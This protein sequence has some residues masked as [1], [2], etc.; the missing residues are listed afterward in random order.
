MYL[1]LPSATGEPKRLVGFAKVSPKVG[2]GEKVTVTID[3]SA[4]DLPMSYYDTTSHAWTIAPGT[5]TVEVGTSAATTTLTGTFTV[6]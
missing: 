6:G 2:R 4:A 1:T 5:Y 3:P